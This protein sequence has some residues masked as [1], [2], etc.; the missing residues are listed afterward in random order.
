VVELRARQVLH[1]RNKQFV[2][3]DDEDRLVFLRLLERVVAR[4]GWVVYAYCVGE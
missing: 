4:F 3:L 1:S 2:F